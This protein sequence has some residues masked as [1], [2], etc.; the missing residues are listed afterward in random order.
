[1]TGSSISAD[2]DQKFG[3]ELRNPESRL[4]ATSS[5]C[6]QKSFGLKNLDFYLQHL[7]RS[8]QCPGIATRFAISHFGGHPD[9]V[10]A[11]IGGKSHLN[12]RCN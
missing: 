4:V 11:K 5:S 12:G 9:Q 2:G 3:K 6:C 7:C 10:V 8:R 1:M